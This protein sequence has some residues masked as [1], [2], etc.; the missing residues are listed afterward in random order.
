MIKNKYKIADK[1]V[2]VN[3]IYEKVH[4]YCKDYITDEEADFSVTI[5]PEDIAAEKQKTDSEYACEGLPAPNFSD[6]QLEELPYTA[7]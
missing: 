7:R 6:A 5:T 4:E 3:S 1:V 2:G